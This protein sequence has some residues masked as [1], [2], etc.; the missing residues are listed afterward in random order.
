M[1]RPMITAVIAAIKTT[2]AA[3]SLTI[4][5]VGCHSGRRWSIIF[6][7]ALLTISDASTKP[8]TK[9]ITAHSKWDK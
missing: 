7:I 9:H 2:P 5:T 8:I 3:I 1:R 6:S 4:F